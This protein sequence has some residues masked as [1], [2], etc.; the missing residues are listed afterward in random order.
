MKTALNAPDH[1]MIAVVFDWDNDVDKLKQMA[2]DRNEKRK[3]ETGRSKTIPPEAFDRMVGGYQAP[4]EGEFD[5]V[6]NVPA[7][8]TQS[9]GT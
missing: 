2:A 5:Q 1:E 4:S 9:E 3:L 6:I 8:W 7:W